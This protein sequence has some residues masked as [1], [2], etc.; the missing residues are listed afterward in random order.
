M[1]RPPSPRDDRPP[2]VIGEHVDVDEDVEAPEIHHVT[3]RHPPIVTVPEAPPSPEYF[4]ALRPVANI[5]R[6]PNDLDDE[7]QV[8][9]KKST[10][11]PFDISSG[12]KRVKIPFVNEYSSDVISS[13]FKYIRKVEAATIEVAKNFRTP[14]PT[15]LDDNRDR[16]HE[17]LDDNRRIVLEVKTD[18]R[19]VNTERL[20]PSEFDGCAKFVKPVAED[21]I[22]KTEFINE[23]D[24]NDKEAVSTFRISCPCFLNFQVNCARCAEQF[25]ARNTKFNPQIHG[26]WVSRNHN[27]NN[28][29]FKVEHS[30]TDEKPDAH[31]AEEQGPP[32]DVGM[33][34]TNKG[35]KKIQTRTALKERR[36]SAQSK[37]SSP[38]YHPTGQ[39]AIREERKQFTSNHPIKVSCCTGV[40]LVDVPSAD[41]CDLDLDRSESH[42]KAGQVWAINDD[43]DGMPRYYARIVKVG[44][45]PFR[46]NLVW[47]DPTAATEKTRR[48]LY[49]TV[50]DSCCD[51]C[52]SYSPF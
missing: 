16:V 7:E 50:T 4:P 23:A 17:T 24:E 31:S 43:Q 29:I 30:T 37:R 34:R 15:A 10:H 12:T 3:G 42:I 32:S 8:V 52:S 9:R 38:K 13:S 44:Y 36:Y 26:N 49:F 35:N 27:R 28:I 39:K 18:S 45:S 40:E 20:Q 21:F 51:T 14:L 41:F 46:V 1:E 6:E 2:L 19:V 11:S 5:Y 48:S 47:L 22:V 25:I 33:Q